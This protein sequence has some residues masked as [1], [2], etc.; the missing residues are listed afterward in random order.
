MWRYINSMAKRSK[1]ESN[2]AILVFLLGISLSPAMAHICNNNASSPPDPFEEHGCSCGTET[3]ANSGTTLF[4]VYNEAFSGCHEGEDDITIE[5]AF[6]QG[7][8]SLLRERLNKTLLS[9]IPVA[10]NGAQIY[11]EIRCL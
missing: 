7:E 5:C 10:T 9:E 4:H 3:A 6:I 11:S 2:A 8:E 1:L